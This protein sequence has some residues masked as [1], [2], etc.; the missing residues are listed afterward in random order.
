MQNL[1]EYS[2]YQK[3]SERLLQYYRDKPALNDG[4]IDFSDANNK[5]A[6]FNFKQKITGQTGNDGTKD[7]KIMVPL[8]CLSNF[9]RTLVIPLI[10]CK[11]NP[12]LTWFTNWSITVC[13][14]DGQVPTFALIDTKICFSCNFIN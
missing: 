5:R 12:I 9:W 1:I 2:K 3:T 4:A 13:A 8:K 14:F 11:I 6:L 10:N 7:V